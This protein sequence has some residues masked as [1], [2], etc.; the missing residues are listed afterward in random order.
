MPLVSVIMPVY[1]GEDTVGK[2]IRS[3]LDQT[4]GDLEL[5]VVDDGSTDFSRK[6]ITSTRDRRLLFLTQ[7]HR[8]APAAR[9]LGITSASGEYLSFLDA[10]DRY[11]PDALEH[12]VAA[13]NENPKV[14][15]FYGDVFWE[16][17]SDVARSVEPEFIPYVPGVSTISM[18]VRNVDEVRFDDHLTSGLEE[19]DLLLRLNDTVRCKHLNRQVAVAGHASSERLL[20]D[21]STSF[22][23]RVYREVALMHMHRKTRA[24]SECL[25]VAQ[26]DPSTPLEKTFVM[27][28]HLRLFWKGSFDLVFDVSTGDH[29]GSDLTRA[30]GYASVGSSDQL[31]HL[32]R[33]NTY[34]AIFFT[35]TNLLM[36]KEFVMPTTRSGVC[37]QPAVV[38]FN[39]SLRPSLFSSPYEPHPIIVESLGTDCDVYH[40]TN[41][42][43]MTARDYLSGSTL[44]TE[45]YAGTLLSI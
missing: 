31:K 8:G 24:Q 25:V 32:V 37:I 42:R 2:A 7:Q 29:E 3:V 30:F 33:G 5:I 28:N 22:I 21:K 43:F 4:H 39:D 45:Q 35:K 20:G 1:N 17:I 19:W 27:L 9:N 26:D 41:V 14:S 18:F 6:A 36:P 13:A 34:Q 11:V 23:E 38:Q 15:L 44:E 10:D 16:K 40:D 12:F